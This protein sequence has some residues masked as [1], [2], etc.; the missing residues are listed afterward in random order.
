[1]ARGPIKV[2]GAPELNVIIGDS[3]VKT[4]QNTSPGSV[5]EVP[6]AGPVAEAAASAQTPLARTLRGLVARARP[7][8][9]LE[10]GTG[11]G[12]ESTLTLCEALHDNAISL[13]GFYSIELDPGLYTQACEYLTPRGYQPHLLRGLS[14]PRNKMA[15]SASHP[16]ALDDLLGYVMTAFKGEPDVVLVNSANSQG[17][18]EFEYLLSM[19]KSRC[20]VVLSD[21]FHVKH[22]RSLQLMQSDP[23]F[24]VLD[25]SR[26]GFGF[27]VAQF[28]P[29]PAA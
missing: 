4:V 13:E 7:H 14:V 21:L 25:L 9:I 1:V 20:Y 16:D 29:T 15:A 12:R 3:P 6:L 22:L 26:D 19:I 17:L 2:G 23:R 28:D 10:I 5:L 27:C 11:S 18:S 24:Q 8:K